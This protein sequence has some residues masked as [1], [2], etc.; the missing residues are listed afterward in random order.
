MKDQYQKLAKALRFC[1]SSKEPCS[2]C[3][4][5]TELDPFDCQTQIML[6]AA[7]ALEQIA[8]ANA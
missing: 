1:G 4:F 2:R 6:R 3:P 7:E 8:E 5:H